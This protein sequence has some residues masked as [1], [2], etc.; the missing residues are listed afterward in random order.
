MFCF[1]MF[2]VHV[3]LGMLGPFGNRDFLACLD[4]VVSVRWSSRLTFESKRT[5]VSV[6][7]E[8]SNATVMRLR[9]RNN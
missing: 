2:D 4:A 3:S 8:T 9:L 7:Y 6:E 5:L 1:V